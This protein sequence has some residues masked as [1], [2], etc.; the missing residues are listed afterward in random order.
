MTEPTLPE[1]VVRL[2]KALKRRKMP[3]AFGGALALAYCT[4]EPRATRDIDM[5]VFVAEGDIETAFNGLPKGVTYDDSDVRKAVRDG[6]ERVWWGK[7]PIDLFF[8]THPF[9]DFA[10]ETARVVPFEK[11]RLPV[12]SGT[13]L[14]VFK[15]FFDRPKDWVD[16]DEVAK[17]NGADF[18]VATAWT[19]QLLGDDDERAER[20]NAIAQQKHA[21][22]QSPSDLAVLQAVAAK[23][24]AVQ[25]SK[26]KGP[27]RCP[28]PTVRGTQCRHHMLPGRSCPTHG[29]TAPT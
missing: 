9:H 12:L 19:V 2:H 20:L 25:P 24:P 22:G 6:Q 29:W 26:P 13:A 10:A 14:V 5:N 28:M 3:H 21:T 4:E 7:T 18:D 11:V 15:A 1:K 17:A 23:R 27:V 16:I 8:S